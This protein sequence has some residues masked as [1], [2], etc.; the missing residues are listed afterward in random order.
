[1]TQSLGLG[2]VVGQ[3]YA[4]LYFSPEPR[5]LADMQ[6]TLA[7]S[8]GSASMG[9]RQ[10]EQWGAVRQVWVRGDRKDYYEASDWFGRI[11]KSAVADT[12]GKKLGTYSTMLDE[13]EAELNTHPNEVESRPARDLSTFP[14][15]L[16]RIEHQGS[17]GSQGSEKMVPGAAPRGTLLS[18]LPSVQDSEELN[19]KAA[20]D[21]KVGEREFLKARIEHLRQF[22]K[23]AEGVWNSPVLK[24]LMK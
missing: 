11:I 5:G 23:R 1:M 17:E 15:K 13:V 9:V 16:R 7:I 20:R 19:T 8:K 10:L 3:I 14:S 22:Q 6:H 21:A 2:R 18:L 12:I 4:Y 24:M